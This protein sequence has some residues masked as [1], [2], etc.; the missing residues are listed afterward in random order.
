MPATGEPDIR[1]AVYGGSF[2]PPHVCHQVTILYV[3]E[4]QPV[5]E[6]WVTPCFK[7]PFEKQLAPYDLRRDWCR[8]LIEPFGPRCRICDVEGEMGGESRSIDTMEELGRRHPRAEFSLVLG[9]DIRS[10]RQRWKRFDELERRYPIIWIGREGH[11]PEGEGL[12]L[13]DISGSMLR[14]AF[15]R[16][17][18]VSRYIPRRVLER[19]RASGWSWGQGE[20]TSPP[21]KTS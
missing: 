16:G 10:E 11:R 12:V 13:P 2:N 15:R 20:T 18:P 7:H 8:A 3:L 4:T 9:S 6:C 19:I 5:D 17:E 14:A 21:A 1:I